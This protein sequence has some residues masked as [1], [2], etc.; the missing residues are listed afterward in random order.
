MTG[1]VTALVGLLLFLSSLTWYRRRSKPE[2]PGVDDELRERLGQTLASWLASTREL[3]SEL[4]GLEQEARISLANIERSRLP[5]GYLPSRE[6][7]DANFLFEIRDA[8]KLAQRWLD[9]A[10][11]VPA[12]ER[13][14]VDLE[15]D[16]EALAELLRLPWAFEREAMGDRDPSADFQDIRRRCVE[17]GEQLARLDAALSQPSVTPYR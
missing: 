12:S 14:R 6:M 1:L 7:E 5:S 17:A 10:A 2:F 3:R 4:A 8:R 11:A 13:E 15:L 16:L 9:E